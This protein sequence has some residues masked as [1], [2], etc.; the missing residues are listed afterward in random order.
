MP[1]KRRSNNT[2]SIQRRKDGTWMAV[3]TIGIKADGKPKKKWMYGKTEKEV[4]EKLDKAKIKYK[5]MDPESGDIP[6]TKWCLIWAYKHKS[7]IKTN[8]R[9]SYITN[10][11]NHI[12]PYIGGVHVNKLTLNHIQATL[13]EC[14]EEGE[15]NSLFLKV[16]N[17]L[18]GALEKAVELKMIERNPCVGVCFPPDNNKKI[19]ALTIEEQQRLIECLKG[20]WYRPLF[21]FYLY[22][23]C[24]LGEALPLRWTDF[25]FEAKTVKIDKTIINKRDMEKH[26]SVQVIQDTPKTKSSNRIVYLTPGIVQVLKDHQA[27]QKEL[28]RKMKKKWTEEALVFPNSRGNIPLMSNVSAVFR[29]IRKAANIQDFTIHGLRHTYASMAFLKG[30]DVKFIS[31]QLGH[32]SVKTTYD[33][34]IDFIKE[35]NQIEIDKVAESDTYLDIELDEETISA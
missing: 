28:A 33:I 22:S 4:V 30:A 9:N 5:G 15:S 16:Y 13:D 24:R 21:L 3:L 17:I 10:I 31:M 27:Y 26:T 35:K 12:S 18:N 20:E 32:K 25:D 29:R 23:G 2:G 34:Y 6:L 19:R 14:Y 1:K 8:T 11:N 7:K